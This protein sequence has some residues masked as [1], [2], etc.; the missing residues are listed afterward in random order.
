MYCRRPGFHKLSCSINVL[1]GSIGISNIVPTLAPLVVSVS[2]DNTTLDSEQIEEGLV[3]VVNG[4]SNLIAD[5]GMVVDPDDTK[6][7]ISWY[8][9]GR[10]IPV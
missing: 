1:G 10:S 4:I 2:Q 5:L 8:V 3:S 6:F 9:D 7:R